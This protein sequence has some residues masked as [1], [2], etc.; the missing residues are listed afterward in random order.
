MAPRN[1]SYGRVD[2]VP[3]L[4]A[5]AF[6][7]SLIAIALAFVA[8]TDEPAA[9]SSGGSMMM[10]MGNGSMEHMNPLAIDG[11]TKAPASRGG[12]TLAGNR[13]DGAT[14][15]RLIARPVWWNILSRQRVAA[16]AYNGIVPGPEIRVRNGE[17]VR[18]KFTN[19]LPEPT[20]VHWHGVDVPNSQDGVPGVTQDPIQP[21]ASQ[22]YE[23]TARPAGDRNGSGTFLYHS[24]FEE[25]RQMPAGLAGSLI[26]EPPAGEAAPKNEH[27]L[28]VSEWTVNPSTG[29][30]R[31]TMPMEGMLPNFFTING[32][33]F[34]D[35]EPINI[36]AG[37]KTYV[38][39]I[40][41]GQFAHPLHLHGTAFRVVARDG[42]PSQDRSLRD[43]LTLESGE[44]A[45]VEFELPK[46][47]WL[48]HCHIGHHATNNGESPGG[49]LT[50]FEAT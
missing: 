24:H 40:N 50:V 13:R 32:K 33:S 8:L 16:W 27:T 1:G 12:T 18:V 45:D 44:R 31:G 41:A 26:I 5:A 9:T 30:V 4:A 43:T 23:F 19:K 15:F 42:H 29:R 47:K 48:F 17:R 21:G 36:K 6:V 35:T 34:P 49:L 2:P 28:I 22:T 38:R 20:T 7:A 11:I 3:I 37:E 39:L 25:D 14:E 46:G 10:G